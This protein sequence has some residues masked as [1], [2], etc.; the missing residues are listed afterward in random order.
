ME[1]ET[2]ARS[3]LD[4]AQKNHQKLKVQIEE[5]KAANNDYQRQVED[6]LVQKLSL[7][8]NVSTIGKPQSTQRQPVHREFIN[9]ITL[10]AT[11][12]F[13]PENPCLSCPSEWIAYNSSCYFFSFTESQVKNNWHDSRADC[14]RRNS[15]LI[16][17]DYPEEQVCLVP[18]EMWGTLYQNLNL[19][20]MKGN[21][22]HSLF[23]FSHL[24][25]SRLRTWM[26]VS[27][28]ASVIQRVRA[29][30]FG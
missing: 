23:A 26:P 29:S 17:V 18:N 2:D 3:A 19:P 11:L 5:K 16:V 9:K 28:S 15:D 12:L 14:M 21:F 13:S 22:S 7:Q 30:G 1:A 10:T 27:G 6:L 24:W 4:S 8:A 25:V 20:V